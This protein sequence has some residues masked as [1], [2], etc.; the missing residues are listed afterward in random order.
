MTIDLGIAISVFGAAFGAWAFVVKS[1]M[2]KLRSDFESTRDALMEL[3][4]SLKDVANSLVN[5]INQTEHRL[6]M[7][8]TEFGFIRR[9]LTKEDE[10]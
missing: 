4:D 10:K 6:T 9:Y 5:H 8:E 1:E 3:K 7:L 2:N